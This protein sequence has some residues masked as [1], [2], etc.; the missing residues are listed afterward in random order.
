MEI[1]LL[2]H[3]QFLVQIVTGNRICFVH[4]IKPADW[5][6]KQQLQS[7]GHEVMHCFGATHIGDLDEET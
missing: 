1:R 6:D 7:L 4:V 3:S 5:N 2:E